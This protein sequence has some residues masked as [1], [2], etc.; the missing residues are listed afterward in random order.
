MHRKEQNIK[1][2]NKVSACLLAR[3]LRNCSLPSEEENLLFW[4]ANPS[5]QYPEEWIPQ[6]EEKRWPNAFQLTE[7]VLCDLKQFFPVSCLVFVWLLIF[8][9]VFV[10]F[11]FVSLNC[12]QARSWQ[13]TGSRDLGNWNASMLSTREWVWCYST[14]MPEG[15]ALKSSWAMFF[16][17]P[18]SPCIHRPIPCTIW[19][20]VWS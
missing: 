10:L 9:V 19:V 15:R 7:L 12:Q 5:L 20:K 1:G 11:C 16:N 14:Y 17:V 3:R 18:L 4:R 2:L 6:E 13:G 8:A